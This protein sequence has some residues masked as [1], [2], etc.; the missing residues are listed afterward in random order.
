MSNILLFCLILVFY[1]FSKD[2]NE[3]V[4]KNNDTTNEE[5]P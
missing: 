4:S 5:H 1:T 3:F 2:L